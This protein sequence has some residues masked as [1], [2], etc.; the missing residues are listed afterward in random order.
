MVKLNVITACMRA[1]NLPR[2]RESIL[3]SSQ[4]HR[5]SIDW[6]VVCDAE[7]VQIEALPDLPELDHLRVI[8]LSNSSKLGG[9]SWRPSINQVLE[10][11]VDGL[12]YI[13]D[14]DNLMHKDL[15]PT[16][17][18]H[19]QDHDVGFLF[20]QLIKEEKRGPMIRYADRPKPGCI[21]TAQF[22]FSRDIIGNS[23]WPAQHPTPDGI[24]IQEVV[25]RNFQKIRTLN[26]VL[27][28]YNRLA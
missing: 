9:G 11:I 25:N 20:Y 2:I 7:F 27:C 12:V 5:V 18:E 10:I 24:F 4:N 8:R 3:S 19:G 22:C 14:D 16:L 17:V 21:D 1:E 28:Y 6:Y 26:R 23:R 15:I 13:L